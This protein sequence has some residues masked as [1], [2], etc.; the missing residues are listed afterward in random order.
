MQR[1]RQCQSVFF[2]LNDQDDIWSHVRHQLPPEMVEYI[3]PFNIDSFRA[4]GL[5]IV[6]SRPLWRNSHRN[7][8]YGFYLMLDS[9]RGYPPEHSVLLLDQDLGL[10]NDSWD[11][12]LDSLPWASYDAI[13]LTFAKALPKWL[14]YQG[15]CRYFDPVYCGLWGFTALPLWLIQPL[16]ERR[17]EIAKLARQFC[18]DDGVEFDKITNQQS[19]QYWPI[20]EAL[21]GSELA[22]RGMQVFDL[23]RQQ[24]GMRQHFTVQRSE[25]QTSPS[26][27]DRVRDG[28]VVLFHPLKEPTYGWSLPPS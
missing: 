3:I 28:E 7:G 23:L 22:R 19:L 27:A 25:W 10:L 15:A 24:V 6:P 4:L 26:L 20:C 9:L 2:L 11:H 18:K 16:L 21:V 14:H 5:P 8:D 13:M 12:Y 17:L 1:S